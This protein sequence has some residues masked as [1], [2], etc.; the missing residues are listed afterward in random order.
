MIWS[1]FWIKFRSR[2]YS[3]NVLLF[4]MRNCSYLGCIFSTILN[5]EKQGEDYIVS[6]DKMTEMQLTRIIAFHTTMI[7]L[8]GSGL[9]TYGSERY[10]QFTKRLGYLMKHCI[11]Y[12]YDCY[13][14]I[15]YAFVLVSVCG[16]S[17]MLFF[18]GANIC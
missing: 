9:K 8:L 11:H 2:S 4:E 16:K 10:R 1:T 3:G 15:V 18:T 7:K 17:I 6:E 13:Q 14:I 5:I 12:T